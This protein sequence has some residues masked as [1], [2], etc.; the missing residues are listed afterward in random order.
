MLLR[1][2]KFYAFKI[3]NILKHIAMTI[4]QKCRQT[5]IIRYEWYTMVVVNTWTQITVYEGVVNI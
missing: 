4:E 1:Y 5:L 3:I 2:S